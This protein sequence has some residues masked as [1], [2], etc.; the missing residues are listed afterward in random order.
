M[1]GGNKWGDEELTNKTPPRRW[2]W[3]WCVFRPLWCRRSSLFFSVWKSKAQPDHKPLR[4]GPEVFCRVRSLMRFPPPIRAAPPVSWPKSLWR[5]CAKL[6][7]SCR[8]IVQRLGLGS[9]R[10]GR[11]SLRA[12]A[13]RFSKKS[14]EKSLDTAVLKVWNP[15]FFVHPFFL[16]FALSP[17][18]LPQAIFLPKIP[19]FWDLRSTLS[20]REK[21]TCRG[22]VL[23]TV[24]DEVAPQE[25]KENPFFLAREKRRG[26]VLK[27][28]WKV[29]KN[30]FGFQDFSDP[31]R[32]FL[33]PLQDFL[34]T[35]LCKWGSIRCIWGS[36]IA[37]LWLPFSA[38]VGCL[39]GMGTSQ[40]LCT[41]TSSTQRHWDVSA[42]RDSGKVPAVF[43]ELSE[44][45]RL[46]FRRVR[47]QTPSSVTFWPSPNS[48]ELSEFL[49]ASY[50]CAKASSPSFSQNSP[51]LLQNSVSSLFRNS[52][53]ETVF[54][55]FPKRDQIRDLFL[56]L[57]NDFGQ[58][59]DRLLSS[60]GVGRICALPMR[61]PNLR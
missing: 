46:R 27:R 42:I 9:P 48:G 41:P 25:K 60:A 37:G 58:M 44:I 55:P 1:A 4:S 40:C 22:W 29:S 3:T 17:R 13:P 45:S 21:A 2:S 32:D 53:L 19:S 47:F 28:V 50:L 20:R 10:P 8:N 51:S 56:V 15:P 16:F 35:I 24:L 14:L 30:S 38:C 26:K 39:L 31:L 7:P 18:T 54:R 12:G 34:Y 52:T 57:A 33:D 61:V 23:G 11:E 59:W 36:D 49:S 5:E 6:W 43:P